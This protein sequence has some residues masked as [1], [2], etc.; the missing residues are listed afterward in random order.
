MTDDPESE[1][2][3]DDPRV[4]AL[5]RASRTI[6]VAPFDAARVVRAARARRRRDRTIIS[7][8]LAVAI[9]VAGVSV[10]TA[11]SSRTHP[12]SVDA[13]DR[14]GMSETPPVPGPATG[15]KWVGMNSLVVAVPVDWP[16]VNSPCGDGS[17][18]VVLNGSDAAIDCYGHDTEV[19]S[20]RLIAL[21]ASSGSPR[22]GTDCDGSARPTCRAAKNFPDQGVRVQVQSTSHDA[23]EQ[24]ER[25]LD[26]ARVLPD[27]WTTVPFGQWNDT[28]MARTAVLEGAGFAVDDSLIAH[29]VAQPVRTEPDAGSPIRVGDTITL[30]PQQSPAT[31]ELDVSMVDRASSDDSDLAPGSA[32]WHGTRGTV[33][34]TTTAV[35]DG[36]PPVA[37]RASMAGSVLDLSLSE[38]A[39]PDAGFCSGFSASHAVFSISGLIEAPTELQVTQD[40]RT[41]TVPI[42]PEKGPEPGSQAP[43]AGPLCPDGVATGQE[44][45]VGRHTPPA[46]VSLAEALARYPGAVVAPRES[47]DEAL[48]TVGTGGQTTRVIALTRWANGSWAVTSVV[49]C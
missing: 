42:E 10:A 26:T 25:I 2:A 15:S 5:T 36:C 34:Y 1:P 23:L 33:A 8:V 29:V 40:G 32:R 3:A 46:G 49:T 6:D 31:D 28:P 37:A 44:R 47:D 21:D 7:S 9:I 45:W 22:E 20:V 35:Y 19:A 18:G 24:T 38:S 27:G 41:R 48:A 17:P 43:S 13:A 4:G 12:G 39:F 16:V 14:S 30:L 11:G